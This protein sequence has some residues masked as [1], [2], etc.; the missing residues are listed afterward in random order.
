[1]LAKMIGVIGQ[2]RFRT[3]I[4]QPTLAELGLEL[5]S[6][7]E[8]EITIFFILLLLINP[9]NRPMGWLACF[10]GFFDETV[11]NQPVV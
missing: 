6:R 10:P 7:S 3:F 11:I 1:M 9:L 5:G 8:V 4:G 2:P